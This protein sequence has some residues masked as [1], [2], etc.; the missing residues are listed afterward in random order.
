MC[1]KYRFSLYNACM[2]KV[3][4]CTEHK[5]REKASCVWNIHERMEKNNSLSCKQ[6]YLDKDQTKNPLSCR[7]TCLD[8]NSE[9]KTLEISVPSKDFQLH[10]WNMDVIKTTIFWIVMPQSLKKAQHF[11]ETYCISLQVQRVS[12]ARN[13]KN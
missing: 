13:Q 8:D 10:M 7:Q 6:T 12:L 3:V 5:C 4:E 11:R 2:L 9:A 1:G